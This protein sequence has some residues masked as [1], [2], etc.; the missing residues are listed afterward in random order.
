MSCERAREELLAGETRSAEVEAHLNTCAACREEAELWEKLGTLPDERPSPALRARFEKMLTGAERRP[1]AVWWQIAAAVLL[2]AAGW[3]AG[4]LVP[5]RPSA[6]GEMAQLRREVRDLREMVTLSLLQQSS[7][8]ERLRGINLS[9]RLDKPDTELIDAL[10]GALGHDPSPDVR[11]AA[12]DALRRYNGE[13]AVRRGLI[14]SLRGQESPLVQIALI[15]ALVETN[16]PGAAEVFRR[17]VEAP[18]A[19]EAVRERAGRGID[20]LRTK[21]VL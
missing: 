2:V 20:E 5:S 18:G 1:A 9:Y 12:V 11:L 6:Q 21:G 19:H 4:R 17:L 16:G 13:A 3:G 15:D 8:S 7:A 10:L 14:E